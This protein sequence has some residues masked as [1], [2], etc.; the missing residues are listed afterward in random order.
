MRAWRRPGFA[1][2][3]LE[4]TP[5]PRQVGRSEDAASQRGDDVVGLAVSADDGDAPAHRILLDLGRRSHQRGGT[6]DRMSKSSPSILMLIF[7]AAIL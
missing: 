7:M 4:T 6:V 5:G 1:G 2:L 3:R